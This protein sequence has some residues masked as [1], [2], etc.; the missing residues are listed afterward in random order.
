MLVMVP[1]ELF[2]FRIKLGSVWML[3]TKDI[4]KPANKFALFRRLDQALFR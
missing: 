3:A 1:W 4:G 2:Q